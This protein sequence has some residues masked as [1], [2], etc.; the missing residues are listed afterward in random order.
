MPW[1]LFPGG[2][3]LSRTHSSLPPGPTLGRARVLGGPVDGLY[4]GESELSFFGNVSLRW[5]VIRLLRNARMVED[6]HRDNA[7]LAQAPISQPVFVLGLPRSGT[8]FLHG[9]MA[10]DTDNLVPRNWQTIYPAPR[11]VDFDP[12]KDKRARAVDRQLRIF[13]GLAPGFAELHPISADSP[14]ECTEITAHVFQ[15]CVLTRRTACRLI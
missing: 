10:Q 4:F 7:A 3:A 8:T 9:L 1:C 6:A 2:R 15:A 11:P 13:A 5:D 14:Q 12:A